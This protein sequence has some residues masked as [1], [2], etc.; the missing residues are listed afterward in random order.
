MQGKFSAAIILGVCIFTLGC[1]LGTQAVAFALGHQRALGAPLM[2]LDGMP[3]YGPF[4]LFERKARAPARLEEVFA[5]P[6]LCA[7]GG[8]VFGIAMAIRM[9]IAED[10]AGVV[11]S[12]RDGAPAD[13]SH[14]GGAVLII[15]AVMIAF[16]NWSLGVGHGPHTAR[17]AAAM[18]GITDTLGGWKVLVA[19]AVAVALFVSLRL[20]LDRARGGGRRLLQGG[21]A[22]THDIRA[23]GLLA[24]PHGM[25]L[26][27][28]RC[29]FGSDLLVYDGPGH[30]LVL[31][32]TRTGKG[33]GLVVPTALAWPHTLIALDP[34]GELADGDPFV[35]FPGTGGYRR[36][37]SHI[38]RFAPTRADSAKFNPLLE[39]R[40]GPNEV[41][42]VQ[43]IVDILTT[44]ARATNEAPFWRT[45]ASHLLVGLI[46]DVL[47]AAPDDR[48][49]LG[50][51][52]ARLSRMQ[53]HA[54]AMR[55]RVHRANPRTGAMETHP[56]IREVA[57]SFLSME[58]RT[59]SN[60]RA[61]AESYLTVF[62][63]DLVDE[64]TAT[65]TFRLA[66]LG[67]LERPVTLYLQPPPSDMERLM[68]L[69]RLIIGQVVRALTENRAID[70]LGRP[71]RHKVLLLLDEFPLLGNLPGFER[72]LGLMAGYGVQAMMV[73]QSVNS[74]RGTY[75]ATNTILDNCDVI[76]SF[77]V[78][79]PATADVIAKL[80]GDVAELAPQR[81]RHFGTGFDDGRRSITW[82][83]ERRPLM[84]TGEALRLPDRTMLIFK[85]DCAPIRARKIRYDALPVFAERLVATSAPTETLTAAHDWRGVTAFRRITHPHRQSPS[86]PTSAQTPTKGAEP[87]MRNI[88]PEA[89]MLPAPANTKPPKP[90]GPRRSKGV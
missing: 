34:K 42:D 67:G 72:A 87:P 56:L 63:D 33:R 58:E 4:T 76:T 53:D 52:R 5:W 28:R 39:V 13:L 36:D 41:R 71:R 19:L 66:D 77:A 61:T 22:T 57:D 7:F 80:A 8:G 15:A 21:W 88:T 70:T 64:N 65:S 11:R 69:M 54:E 26:G 78:N 23:S 90:R 74:I 60:V 20:I 47:Y 30:A 24:A 51:V 48:K 49:C 79:D 18:P 9:L 50:E 73:C 62:A 31:G 45:A 35:D 38:L 17:A 68:P 59:Q 75:G 32:A 85:G 89:R 82:R 16:A 12:N 25:V 1:F 2:V 29:L 83:E 46:L 27:A 86:A 6:M 14:L 81:S 10:D 37:F 44:P 43:N 55:E 84:M 3:I 40:R